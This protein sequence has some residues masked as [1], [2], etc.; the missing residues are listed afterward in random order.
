MRLEA[1]P[2]GYWCYYDGRRSLGQLPDAPLSEILRWILE[3][4]NLGHAKPYPD[5]KGQIVSLTIG[6]LAP[7]DAASSHE[8]AKLSGEEFRALN[9]AGL[10]AEARENGCTIESLNLTKCIWDSASPSAHRRMEMHYA[11]VLNRLLGGVS[12]KLQKL[13][14]LPIIN[15]APDRTR[16][17]LAEATRCYLF[18]LDTACIA[19]CRACLEDT[20]N[21]SLTDEMR[22]EWVKEIQAKKQKSHQPNLYAL[23]EV[24]AKHGILGGYKDDA[25]YVRE[26]GNQILHSSNEAKPHK[27]SSGEVL[28]KTRTII[29]LIYGEQYNPTRDS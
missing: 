17:Y 19:M 4:I 29:G 5:S 21:E 1:V 10:V 6:Q 28:S 18:K 14:L 20:L 16:E 11:L 13:E 12:K 15:Q 7:S 8:A 9:I 22:D 26:A 2:G 24:C 25:H 27:H 23:I 3:Q